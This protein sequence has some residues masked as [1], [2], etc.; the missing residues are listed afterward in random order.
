MSQRSR[1]DPGSINASA[2]FGESSS[3]V[4]AGTDL[5]RLA[6]RSEHT[7]IEDKHVD[8]APG[9]SPCTQVPAGKAEKAESESDECGWMRSSSRTS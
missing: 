4:N 9:V 8:G 1:S 7:V 2:E 6:G 5:A 3:S